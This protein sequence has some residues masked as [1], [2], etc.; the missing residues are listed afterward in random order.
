MLY[1]DPLISEHTM[2]W[3][4]TFIINYTICPF[5]KGPVN[6]GTLRIITSDTP[7]K[8]QALKDLITEIQFLEANP[9]VETTLLIFARAFKDFFSY[10]DFI[11]LAEQLI[12][13]LN[14]EGIYQLATFHPDYYFADTS[15]DD[16]AN[17]TNRSPYP[18][19]H[20][21]R[22]DSL[23]KAITA[24]GDTHTIPEKNIATM[25]ELGLEKMKQL[26]ASISIP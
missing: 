22:E 11:S 2:K 9:A 26:L 21:L 4:R 16:V 12:Q 19:I 18:M 20:L 8:H 14:Y 25:N 10:L 23:D 15:P 13:N 1:H 3:V 17:Y 7:K 5:A 24:Y 6:K